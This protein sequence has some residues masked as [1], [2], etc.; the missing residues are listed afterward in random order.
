MRSAKKLLRAFSLLMPLF[1]ISA[2]GN[3]FG[4]VPDDYTDD[5]VPEIT[6]RVARISYISGDAQIR[7]AESREWEKAVQNLPIVEGDEIATSGNALLEIQLNKDSYLRLSQNSYIKFLNLKDE[8][9]AV[10]L[11]EGILSA[12]FFEFDK[13]KTYFEIDAPGTTVAVQKKGLYRVDAQDARSNEKAVRITV[14]QDGEARIYST[15]SGFNLRGGRSAKVF[16]EGDYAGEWEMADAQNFYDEFD[17]WTAKSD[18]A[19]FKRMRDSYYDKYY[20][21]DIYGAEDLNAYGQWIYTRKY[22]YV[23]RPD[24]TATGDYANWSPYRYGSWRWIPPYGWTW[25]NDESWGWATYHYGRWIFVDNYWVW[26]PYGADRASRS[27]WRPALIILGNYGNNVY[28]CPLPYDYGYY[29]Y[30]HNYHRRHH[31]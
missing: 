30:N 14:N 9:I 12:R 21:R 17:E 3:V 16:L 11:S 31:R 1:I 25:V 22:G 18:A 2:T 6:A 28:W 24:R 13:D 29:N 26:T 19:I 15:N 27:W 4:V 5:Y 23:W 10:S 8:G 7:R 20:D